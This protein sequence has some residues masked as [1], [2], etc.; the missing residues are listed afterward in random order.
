[1]VLEK[2][3]SW[4]LAWLRVVPWGPHSYALGVRLH[5]GLGVPTEAFC[6]GLGTCFLCVNTILAVHQ[7]GCCE[8]CKITPGPS[9][10]II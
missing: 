5:Q 8:H 9:V 10:W 1:M 2:Q 6:T 7:Q 3:F 4:G